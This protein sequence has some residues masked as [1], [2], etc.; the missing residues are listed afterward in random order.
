[1]N[2]DFSQTIGEL[3]K[4]GQLMGKRFK[5][6]DTFANAATGLKMRALTSNTAGRAKLLQLLESL[7]KVAQTHGMKINED[8]VSQ[9]GFADT[10]ENLFGSEAP[11]SFLGG[12]ER[13]VAKGEQAL[14]AGADLASGHPV[15]AGMEYSTPRISQ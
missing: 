7:D 10:M 15:H 5:L 12:I 14:S 2:T 8:L 6:G 4:I 9:A 11:T 1:M 3:N 13:G